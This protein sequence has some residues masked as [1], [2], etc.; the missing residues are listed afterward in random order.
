MQL[1][2]FLLLFSFLT[3]P[4]QLFHSFSVL[5]SHAFHIYLPTDLNWK[6]FSSFS[7][8]QHHYTMYKGEIWEVDTCILLRLFCCIQSIF[9]SSNNSQLL[10]FC[11]VC[12]HSVILTFNVV[13]L[14]NFSNDI[15]FYDNC[16][17]FSITN[18]LLF[19]FSEHSFSFM[20]LFPF[21]T[22]HFLL[23]FKTS[24]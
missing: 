1:L 4:F 10:P 22:S 11:F 18:Q 6:S 2:S 13:I 19:R 8:L 20:P 5:I 21:H 3:N 12:S 23:P 24:K 15:K 9:H 17:I 7:C 16:V 14:F